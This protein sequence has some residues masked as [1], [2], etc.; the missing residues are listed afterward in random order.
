MKKEIKDQIK[1]IG[2]SLLVGFGFTITICLFLVFIFIP[3]ALAIAY[4]SA[5]WLLLY[6]VHLSLYFASDYYNHYYL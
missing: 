4:S 2:I 3:V 1:K 5:W 6:L